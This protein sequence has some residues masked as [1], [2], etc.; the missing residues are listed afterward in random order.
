ME[1]FIERLM[2][3]A[4]WIMAPIYLG[5]SLALLALGIKFFSGSFSY[6]H[7]DHFHERSGADTD[8]FVAD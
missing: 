2:Y 1:R 5:L 7:R 4:R 3:S 8:H 6:L